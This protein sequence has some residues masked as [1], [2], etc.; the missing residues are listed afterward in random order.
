[1]GTTAKVIYNGELR[2]TCTHVQ[3]G[4][5]LI[6]DA[7]LDN[8]GKGQAF[9]PTDLL[10]T[11]LVACMQTIVGIYCNAHQIAFLGCEGSVE[12]IMYSSPRRIGELNVHLDFKQNN[13]AESI[14]KR[15]QHAAETCPV[16]KSLHPDIAMH[17]ICTF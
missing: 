13:W 15:I 6:T 10:A 14:Q 1:M 16:A 8:N 7:P 4:Q 9:S 5:E 3:S 11:S 17:V 12:K 2:T